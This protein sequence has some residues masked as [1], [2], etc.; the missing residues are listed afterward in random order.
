MS[1]NPLG[2]LPPPGRGD[3]APIVGRRGLAGEEIPPGEDRILTVPNL[4]TLVRLLC[5]PLF[6]WLLFG[7]DLL[8]QAGLLLGVLGATDWVDGWVARRFHQVSNLGKML[9]PVVD[10]LL[11]VVGVVS[12]IVVGAVPLWFGILVVGREVVMSAYVVAIVGM[13]AR[14]L[15]VTFVGKTGAF[16]QMVAFPAFLVADDTTVPDW[17]TALATVTA[18]GCG[19]VG[20]V[21][22]YWA[23]GTYVREGRVALAEG[24]AARAGT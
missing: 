7:K 8:W 4:V 10:R 17:I 12:I 19:L 6:L 15:D 18:W 23:F 22:G 2:D 14:R 11:M 9:D 5:L 3:A 24:R 21:F 1:T 13:G 16:L 20:L